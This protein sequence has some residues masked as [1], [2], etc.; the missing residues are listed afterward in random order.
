ML[1]EY[2][3]KSTDLNQML[4]RISGAI[5]VLKEEVEKANEEKPE[6]SDFSNERVKQTSEKNIVAAI[7]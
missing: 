7:E 1:A 6:K 3:N 5:Q 2:E 4:L